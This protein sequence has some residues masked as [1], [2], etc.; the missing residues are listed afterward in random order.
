M[1]QHLFKLL[2]KKR[3]SNFLIMLE[4]FVAFVI[5][6]AVGS[7]SAYLYRG[8]M[9]SS[10]IKPENVW[11]IYVNYNTKNDTLRRENSDLLRQKILSYREVKSLSFSH[12]NVPFGFSS[13]NGNIDYKGK[14][15]MS[16]TISA[17]EG[18]PSVLGLEMV[19]GQWFKNEDTLQ[20]VHP[21]VITQSL[22]EAL[23][24]QEDAVGKILSNDGELKFG[25][26]VYQRKVVGVIGGFKH[27]NDF[28]TNDHCVFQAI[29]KG[30]S[31]ILLRVDPSVSAE[32]EAQFAASLQS[33]GK[34]WT[35][36]ILHLDDMKKTANSLILIPLIILGIVIGFLIVN[37]ALGLFGVLFQNINRRRSEIGIRRA[38]GATGRNITS[39]FIG[40]MSVLATFSIVIGVFFAVQFP[41]L[42]VFDIE[43]AV[44]LW[45]IFVAVVAVYGLVL[46]CSWLP[47]KQAAAIYPAMALHE[48]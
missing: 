25:A 16:E 6:F 31:T 9:K 47:S 23:F 26:D 45:G 14:N 40:E 29:G 8:Y 28:Q 20:K 42:H 11:T 30:S 38:M 12:S 2:W 22:K 27:K 43:T 48:E 13:S 10:D 46:L 15:T 34:D 41:I 24:G 36:E 37:V 5:L 3:K 39:Q 33:L 44:Y 21:V 19:A 18:Y 1:V 7:L 17:E 4:I 32:F 35:V